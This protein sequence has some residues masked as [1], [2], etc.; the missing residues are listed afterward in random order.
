[1][2][3]FVILCMIYTVYGAKV[4]PVES[5]CEGVMI[6]KKCHKHEVISNGINRPYHL[7]YF[8]HSVFFSYNA[9]DDDQDTFEIGYVKF[10]H[11]VPIAINSTKNGFAIAIDKLNKIAYFG[12]SEG[13]YEHDLTKPGEIKHIIIKHDIW[14]MFYKHHLY[15]IEYPSQRLHK[16]VGNDT[17]L[18]EHITEK[19]YQFAIDDHQNTYI[20]TKKGLYEI[21]NGTTER[22]LLKGPK[23]YR[24]IVINNKG[25]PYFCSQSGIYIKE[26]HTLKEIVHVKNIFG[27]AF[28]AEDNF[29]YSNPHEIVRL[30]PE[31]NKKM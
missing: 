3:V 15:F 25:V 24:A 6:E 11:K 31:P 22:I 16:K 9:G 14:H 20:T 2:R 23:V 1:M 30:L 12:G 27:L 10:G 28:D 5:K 18:V 21:K 7:S 26:E 4:K 29:I 8:N 19:I 13:I 17:E